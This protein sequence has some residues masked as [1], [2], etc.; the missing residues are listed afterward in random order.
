MDFLMG[1][2]IF[3]YL[4]IFFGKILEVSVS[5]VRLVLINRGERTKGSILAFFDIL[6]WVLI[7]GTVLAGFQN[8]WLRLVIFAAAFAIGNFVGSWIEDKL[9]FGLSS[10][11]VIVPECEETQSVLDTLR[12]RGFAVTVMHGE[13]KDGERKLLMLHIKRKRIPQA[14]H[15]IK[16]YLSDAMIV[17]NDAKNIFGGYIRK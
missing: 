9:A 5:T 4:F 1:S 15:I 10:L 7:T 2:S 11:Q 6:L 8:D 13:G 14:V 17:V 12:A 16:S 3:V